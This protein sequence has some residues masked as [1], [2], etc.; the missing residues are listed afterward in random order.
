MFPNLPHLTKGASGVGVT[1]NNRPGRYSTRNN[2]NPPPDLATPSFAPSSG[3]NNVFGGPI[4]SYPA[5]QGPLNPANGLFAMTPPP[6]QEPG[7]FE[8][9]HQANQS[10][11]RPH[12]FG[13][14]Q[15]NNHNPNNHH[16]NHNNN[17][18]NNNQPPNNN[19]NPYNRGGGLFD[20]LGG[21]GDGLGGGGRGLFDDNN[22]QAP[23]GLEIRRQNAQRG[24]PAR[25]GG[26]GSTG[27]TPPPPDLGPSYPN[28][29]GLSEFP[30]AAIINP[31]SA[32]LTLPYW[33][34][35]NHMS[36]P[37]A[38]QQEGAYNEIQRL[39]SEPVNPWGSVHSLAVRIYNARIQELQAFLQQ[40]YT[41]QLSSQIM[42][43]LIEN[44]H[45]Y[46]EH[47]SSTPSIANLFRQILMVLDTLSTQGGLRY[48]VERRDLVVV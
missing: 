33:G 32:H 8:M 13:M 24:E 28:L 14:Y 5:P 41:G 27:Q 16:N 6:S 36:T 23:R 39:L 34:M 45:D 7:L 15:S 37:T 21:G 44:M 46:L 22:N 26:F 43:M 3:N 25:H 47:A 1:R 31:A 29:R 11:P 4:P 19:D 30:T 10:V 12:A 35:F 18:N 17:N 20:G 2:R 40:M 48:N 9:A 38:T 42:M